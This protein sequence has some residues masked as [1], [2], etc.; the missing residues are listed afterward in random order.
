MDISDVRDLY[1]AETQ[2]RYERIVADLLAIEA[3][4]TKG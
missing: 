4:G 3:G 1:F 2:E